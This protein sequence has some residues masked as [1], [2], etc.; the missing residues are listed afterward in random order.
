[1]LK[2]RL[3]FSLLWQK[4][5]FWLSRN[6]R[7]QKAGNLSWIEKNYN[8][9]VIADAI[10]E[11]VVVNISRDD[12]RATMAAFAQQIGELT[13]GCFVP[14]AAGGGVRTLEDASSL[15]RSGADKIVVNT[16][17][18]DQPALVEELARTY[19]RQCVVASIDYKRE[20]GVF[21]ANGTRATGLDVDAAVARAVELGA[22][23]V[24][25]TS[26]DRDGTGQGYDIE[27]LERVAA[28][29]SVPVIACGGVGGYDHLAQWLA[30]PLG[31][32]ACTAN[33]FNFLGGGLREARA[34]IVENGT[35]LATWEAGWRG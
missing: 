28:R 8:F 5:A 14:L 2:R 6:F 34:H 11:L 21:T 16:P 3:I 33:I 9:S 35:P 22:G 4:D 13:R 29:T 1:M 23:E 12:K 19:G 10:D 18:F 30:H 32:A 20:G 15:L 7:V 31:H 17:L 25:L 26:M 24:L 27:V